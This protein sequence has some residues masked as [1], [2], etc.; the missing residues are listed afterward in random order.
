MTP[1]RKQTLQNIFVKDAILQLYILHACDFSDPEVWEHFRLSSK[2]LVDLMRKVLQG[3]INTNF[4]VMEHLNCERVFKKENYG[5]QEPR[6]HRSNY[7]S[8]PYHS[9]QYRERRPIENY[10]HYRNGIFLY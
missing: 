9:K 6:S 4:H 3:A 10:E 2:N 5:Y 7:Q 8:S 1:L